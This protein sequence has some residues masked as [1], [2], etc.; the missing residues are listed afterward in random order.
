MLT[1]QPKIFCVTTTAAS[2]DID[3]PPP[4]ADDYLLSQALQVCIPQHLLTL[5]GIPP[6]ISAVWGNPLTSC[7]HSSVSPLDATCALGDRADS[8][9]GLRRQFAACTARGKSQIDG[10][11]WESEL[12]I[13]QEGTPLVC[14]RAA[15]RDQ[16]T[17]NVKI[18]QSSN[19]FKGWECTSWPCKIFCNWLFL[20]R[21]PHLVVCVWVIQCLPCCGMCFYL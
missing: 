3:M 2:L 7:F 13:L 12:K 6:L 11:T 16:S 17:Q 15:A 9:K 8:K 14:G 4:S 5:L 18:R 19:T 10:L 21:F 1:Q 20:R